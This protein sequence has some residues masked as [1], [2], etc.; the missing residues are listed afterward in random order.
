VGNN[1]LTWVT[2]GVAIVLIAAGWWSAWIAARQ[3]NHRRDIDSVSEAAVKHQ[4]LMNPIFW[5]Y[6]GF[7]V[8]VALLSAFFYWYYG[9]AKSSL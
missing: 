8:V 4:V 9:Y 2:V 5:M 1:L 3:K 6:I 7:V